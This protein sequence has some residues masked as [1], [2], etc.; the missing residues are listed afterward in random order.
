LANLSDVNVTPTDG[1][2]LTWDNATS[3]WIAT[4]PAGGGG[5]DLPVYTGDTDTDISISATGTGTVALSSG[6]IPITIGKHPSYDEIEVAANGTDQAINLRSRNGG[7][8]YVQSD[9]AVYLNS[10]DPLRIKT[11]ANNKQLYIQEGS[12]KVEIRVTDAGDALKLQ[13]D[14]SNVKV[15]AGDKVQLYSVNGTYIINDT[16]G[17]AYSLPNS[18]PA[19]DQILK[20][21]GNGDLQWATESAGGG[22]GISEIVE[23]TTP[24][25]GGTLS[26]ADASDP[27]GFRKITDKSGQRSIVIRYNT[28][29]T[30]T[31]RYLE[32]RPG[33]TNDGSTSSFE[34]VVVHAKDASDPGSRADLRLS[35]GGGGYVSMAGGETGHGSAD[36]S[37][38]YTFP[39]SMPA[40]NQI[41][42]AGANGNL[43]WASD[44]GG[45]GG[46]GGGGNLQAD[47]FL[48]YDMNAGDVV[49]ISGNGTVGKVGYSV[50]SDGIS[51]LQEGPNPYGQYY[52]SG[53][54]KMIA[55]GNILS[56]TE[57][58]NSWIMGMNSDGSSWGNSRYDEYDQGWGVV[59]DLAFHPT[60]DATVY[61]IGKTANWGNGPT[62]QVSAKVAQIPYTTNGWYGNNSGYVDLLPGITGHIQGEINPTTLEFVMMCKE[63]GTENIHLVYGSFDQNNLNNIT[64]GPAIEVNASGLLGMGNSNLNQYAAFLFDENNDIWMIHHNYDANPIVAQ[65][66]LVDAGTNAISVDAGNSQPITTGSVWSDPVY[67][68]EADPHNPNHYAVTQSSGANI[69]Y[70]QLVGGVVTEVSVNTMSNMAG[71]IYKPSDMHFDPNDS[72]KAVYHG[73]TENT[74]YTMITGVTIDRVTNTFASV[75][76][77]YTASLYNSAAFSMAYVPQYDGMLMALN[78]DTDYGGTE[79]ARLEQYQ[80]GGLA[81]NINTV[82]PIG[83]LQETGVAGESKQVNLLGALSTVHSGLTPN[84][85]YEVGMDGTL[86]TAGGTGVHEIGV[87]ISGT[88]LLT[89]NSTNRGNY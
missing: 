80:I 44:N 6:G 25:L 22:G 57:G 26:L 67:N 85:N 74:I 29:T 12:D 17:E 27:N 9:T 38:N 47:L 5:G 81:S 87:A 2:S 46:G 37:W 52:F 13:S 7:N 78:Y 35:V 10:V 88:Q 51:F 36:W 77:R 45:N 56:F 68:V 63:D 50:S 54:Q 76:D 79:R 83:I 71:E 19:Q 84:T 30:A 53:G 42:K 1:Q 14:T 48:D 34:K 69:I 70:F 4:T 21:D 86:T 49:Y 18:T 62:N 32:L 43:A 33:H 64:V 3:T 72:T 61:Q 82:E 28:D 58:G 60:D 8:A 66:L 16:S 41:L 65:R 20:A 31:E 75:G 59:R 15:V 73:K 40:P 11:G 39:N 23:D 89:I 55:R 24:T